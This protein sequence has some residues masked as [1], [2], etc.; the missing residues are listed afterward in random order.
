MEIIEITNNDSCLENIWPEKVLMQKIISFLNLGFEGFNKRN[1]LDLLEADKEP[2][3]YEELF[4]LQAEAAF[5]EET[6]LV[7]S[8]Q[9]TS[10]SLSKSS[11]YFE[12][13]IN[14]FLKNILILTSNV[15]LKILWE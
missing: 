5:D 4:Q 11:S 6:E 15:A 12:Q 14:I 1:V 10:K 9:L 2:L 8:K 7:V 3:S 13:G